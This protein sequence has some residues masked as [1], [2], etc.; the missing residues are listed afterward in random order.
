MEKIY[1]D[2]EVLE[3]TDLNNSFS[4]LENKI[5]K[6]F[7]EFAKDPYIIIDGKKYPR[8]GAIEP[9]PGFNYISG[10]VGNY[11]ENYNATISIT[12]PYQPPEGYSFQVFTLK[13]GGF[14]HLSTRRYVR[15]TQQIEAGI[16]Q[17]GT[18]KLSDLKLIGWRLVSLS[19]N[20][21][22]LQGA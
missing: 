17:G 6:F 11:S 13:A 4:E 19:E 10:W 22:R 14:I 1:K 18:A 15:E 7:E 2:G 16:Y 5:T 8:S 12:A 9:P 20:P 3:A 21:A